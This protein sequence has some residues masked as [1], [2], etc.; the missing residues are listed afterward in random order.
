MSVLLT[1]SISAALAL[2]PRAPLPAM[3]VV[4]VAHPEPSPIADQRLTVKFA[5]DV[6]AR[7]VGGEVTLSAGTERREL[8]R[9]ITRHGLRFRPLI[10]LPDAAIADLEERAAQR[11]GRAQPDL[12]GVLVVALDETS[13]A[14]FEAAGA[15]LQSL[16]FV[17]YA[18]IQ[19]IGAPPPGDIS[20]TTPDYSGEQGY[21]GPDPGIDA[22]AAASLGIT[23]ANVRLSDCEYGWEDTHEDLVDRDLNLEAGQTVPSWVASYGWD[24]HGT[25]ALGEAV[26]VDN[27][28][29]C[30]GIA[31]EAEIGTY[32]EY[33]EE[34]GS[35]RA[36]AIASAIADSDVGDVVMLEMQTVTRPRGDYGPAELDP[37]VWVVVK[38][39]T[40]AGVVVVGA[41]GNGAEDLDSSWY[42]VN[43]LARGDSGAIIV[44]A[45]SPDTDHE[46]EYFST[47]GT[48]VDVQGWGSRVFTLGYG[49]YAMLGGDPD[50]AYTDSFSGTSS[51]TP[52]VTGSC[53]AV[54]DHAIVTFG[55]PLAPRDLRALLA[56]T[57][58]P[59]GFG[60]NIGPLPDISAAFV[61]LDSDSDGAQDSAYGGD[62]CDDEDDDINTDASEIWYDGIDSDCDQAD[63]FDADADGHQAAVHGGGDC[64]DTDD[65]VHPEA[66]DVWYDGV[67]SDCDG[68]SDFDADGDGFD[69]AT[70]GGG[71][72]RDC[73]DTDPTVHPDAVDVWYDGIDTDCDGDDDHD[74]DGDGAA[75]DQDCDNADPGVH[76]NANEIWSDGVDQDCDGSDALVETP[77]ELRCDGCAA[78]PATSGWV[79]L[80][81]AVIV[82]RRRR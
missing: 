27:G 17:E 60:V 32:P 26:A 31:P 14:A 72:P 30:T 78:G 38:V 1:A 52:I 25:A 21:R 10:Q 11:S 13:P 70:H 48:R 46:P 53:L 4:A 71:A 39:G 16:P 28:Y 8:D 61:E 73:D 81:G 44:G 82:R 68:A 50:Q 77:M 80:L 69:S 55:A 15:D 57:G 5:D 6:S 58:T 24:S 35:R 56:D 7:A 47:Y 49:N 23:G 66:A 3:P 12:R 29:G 19:L 33:T 59:Q 67:D 20:P 9:I 75:V 36:T 22:D 54:Q 45:G 63:D 62:D 51:A 37:N 74:A 76:P 79:A 34:E 42:T 2:T 40:D 43:Y 65:S 64:D 41:A 18:F